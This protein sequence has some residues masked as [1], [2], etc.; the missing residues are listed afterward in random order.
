MKKMMLVAVL[1]AVAGGFATTAFAEK[2]PHMRNALEK[3]EDARKSL[4]NATA[5]KGGHRAKAMALVADAI[6]EVKAGIE[7]DNKN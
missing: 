3:L 2:Q 5:D 7:F 6:K 1:A 4:E